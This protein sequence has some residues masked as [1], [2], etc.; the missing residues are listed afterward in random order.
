MSGG[1]KLRIASASS[2]TPA[3]HDAVIRLR[4]VVNLLT[5]LIV[6]QNRSHRNFQRDV[7]AL[8]PGAVGTFA[9]APA[10]GFVFWIETEMNERVVAL[11]RL[12]DHVAAFAAI[13]ARRSAARDELLPP[14]CEA[15]IAAV[16]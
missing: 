12:H 9:V 16:T 5:G 3:N 7:H 13:A 2:P 6:V 4:E 14:E 15:A 11:A 8:A 10:L 1:R